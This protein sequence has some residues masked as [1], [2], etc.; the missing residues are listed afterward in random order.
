MLQVLSNN[1]IKLLKMRPIPFF[2]H[3]Y[4]PTKPHLQNGIQPKPKRKQKKQEWDTSHYILTIWKRKPGRNTFT[5]M[6]FIHTTI[7]QISFIH[8]CNTYLTRVLYACGINQ[9][10]CKRGLRGHVI[11]N[12]CILGNLTPTLSIEMRSLVARQ[13]YLTL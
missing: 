2:F 9:N 7:T 3:P 6:A 10:I 1:K 12:Y 5:C 4:D 11:M 13:A 8:K